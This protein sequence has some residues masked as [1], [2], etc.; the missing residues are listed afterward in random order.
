MAI[1]PLA[2]PTGNPDGGVGLCR[3]Q[4]HVVGVD[5]GRG[6]FHLAA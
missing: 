5:K 6:V 2:D 1:A 4:I 3:A